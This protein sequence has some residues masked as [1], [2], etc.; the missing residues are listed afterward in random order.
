MPFGLAGAPATFL[1]AMNAT[2]KPL[3]RKCVIVFFDDILV[4]SQT[5]SDHTQHLKEVLTLLRNDQWKVKQSKSSFGQTQIAYL[6]HVINKEGVYSDPSKIDKV[7]KWPTP[8]SAKDVQ[9]FLGFAG[10]YHKFIEHFDILAR[11]LF[12]L[13]KKG[14]MF[15]WTDETNTTFEELKKRLI[16]APVLKLSDFT[17]KF[18]IDTDACDTWVGAV[19]QQMVILSPI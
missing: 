14:C 16:A 2:L 13:L 6:G 15:V 4:Y 7:A 12:N 11:P 10:Y 8:V 3:L 9:C 19:L 17:K 18:I 1:G 5:L